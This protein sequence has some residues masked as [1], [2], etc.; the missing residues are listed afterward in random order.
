MAPELID[1]HAH[2][3]FPE[4]SAGLSAFLDRARQAGVREIVTIG[5]SIETSLKAAALAGENVSIYASAGVHPH[6][7]R[8]LGA[9][10]IESLERIAGE[11]RVLAVGEIGLDYYRDR[12]PRPVQRECMRQQ[13]ELACRVKKPVVFHIRDAYDDFLRIV[14]DYAGRMEGAVMHC[15][16]G[17]WKIARQ[18]LDWGFYLSIPGTVTYPRAERVQEVVRRAPLDRLLLETDAPFLAPMPVRGKTNEPAFVLHTARKIADLRGEELDAIAACT[19][20]NA[21]AVFRMPG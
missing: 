10:E 6:G 20:A 1:T 14:P 2:L 8:R 9:E 12:Q 17:D 7:A 3:D 16:A 5:I 15:F 11:E 13:I 21:R 18:C 4:F 19:T